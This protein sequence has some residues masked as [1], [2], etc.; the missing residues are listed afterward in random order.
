[1]RVDSAA[2]WIGD[3]VD[4]GSAGGSTG[5]ACTKTCPR[6]F[7]IAGF[8]GRASGAVNQLDF[9]C[10]TLDTSGRLIGGG[11]FLGAVG[12]TG[13]TAKGPYRCDTDHPGYALKGHSSARID[14][15][16]LHCRRAPN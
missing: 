1:V 9:E 11:Q 3:P 16:G 8:R 10:R 13:G 4:R 12:G 15:I 6:D 7:A 5:G 14:A 2:H